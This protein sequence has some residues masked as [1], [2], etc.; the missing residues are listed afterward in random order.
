MGRLRLRDIFLMDSF[1][2]VWYH[3]LLVF[4]A[5]TGLDYFE[6][7]VQIVP[8]IF[9][10]KLY[11]LCSREWKISRAT[12]FKKSDRKK[13][14]SVRLSM[15]KKKGPCPRLG[16]VPLPPLGAT[17]ADR[18]GFSIRKF[19]NFIKKCVNVGGQGV[20]PLGCLP[21]WGRVGV[22]L[23]TPRSNIISFEDLSQ[24]FFVNNWA[25]VPIPRLR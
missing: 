14:T 21:L 15:M 17:A 12:D 19:G 13:L 10:I 3:L 6:G 5:G 20:L 25:D 2:F 8:E 23:A 24:Q 11:T 7:P 4:F 22:T 1:S 9:F 18:S 16:E